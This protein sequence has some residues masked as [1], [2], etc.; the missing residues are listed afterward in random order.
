VALLRLWGRCCVLCV[1]WY[2]CCVVELRHVWAGVAATGPLFGA[3]LCPVWCPHMRSVAT[4]GWL[5]LLMRVLLSG[6]QQTLV[7]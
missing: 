4:A 2:V 5:L 3:N 6:I 1:V 7:L